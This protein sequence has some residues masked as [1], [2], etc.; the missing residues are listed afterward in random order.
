MGALLLPFQF[1]YGFM[2]LFGIYRQSVLC[3]IQRIIVSY[4]YLV[5][6]WRRCFGGNSGTVAEVLLGLLRHSGGGAL[7]VTLKTLYNI[8]FQL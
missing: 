7:G 8:C 5:A 6:Q 4:A 3:Y 2:L 1:V